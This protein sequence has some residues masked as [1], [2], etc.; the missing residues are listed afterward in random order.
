MKLYQVSAIIQNEYNPKPWLYTTG[1]E[2][3]NLSKIIEV[4]DYIRER[5]TA[6]SMWIDV[7]DED[8]NKQTIFHECYVNCFG[9]INEV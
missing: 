4:V 6:L 5:N 8:N 1:K 3:L 2:E 7:Y 9:Q